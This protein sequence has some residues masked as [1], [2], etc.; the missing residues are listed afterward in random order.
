[1]IQ[2]C[3]CASSHPVCPVPHHLVTAGRKPGPR[4]FLDTLQDRKSRA[5]DELVGSVLKDRQP[6]RRELDGLCS[7]GAEEGLD[8]SPTAI[9][10]P[11]AR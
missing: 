1:M 4:G 11:A 6:F 7:C 10:P 5:E 8:G 2:V 9:A 3:H